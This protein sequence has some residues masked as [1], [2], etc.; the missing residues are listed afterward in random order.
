MKT[1]EQIQEFQE[2]VSE[3]AQRPE[4]TNAFVGHVNN[5]LDSISGTNFT[6]SF[7]LPI[8]IPKFLTQEQIDALTG[9]VIMPSP[10]AQP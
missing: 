5:V 9:F 7:C 6:P 3:L 10:V 1:Q 4:A 2:L 8:Y